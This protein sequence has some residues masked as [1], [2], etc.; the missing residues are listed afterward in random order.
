MSK[1]ETVIVDIAPTGA[2][3]VKVEGCPGPACK[4]LTKAL[5]SK[6]GKVQGTKPT[7]EMAWQAQAQGRTLRR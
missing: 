5:E 7:T 1:Q 6:L 4:D 3:E 2:V